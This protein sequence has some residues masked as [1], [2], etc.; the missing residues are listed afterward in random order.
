M[1]LRAIAEALPGARHVRLVRCVLFSDRDVA[2]Y[3]RALGAM[4]ARTD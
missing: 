1:A 4:G 2:A 3:E